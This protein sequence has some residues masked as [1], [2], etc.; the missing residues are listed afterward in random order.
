M[1]WK[2]WE[3]VSAKWRIYHEGAHPK[4]QN[5]SLEFAE[6]VLGWVSS[7]PTGIS[8]VWKVD[9]MTKLAVLKWSYYQDM[10]GFTHDYGPLCKLGHI[11]GAWVLELSDKPGFRNSENC[12]VVTSEA[13]YGDRWLQIWFAMCKSSVDLVYWFTVV[14]GAIVVGVV[15]REV[16]SLDI[17]TDF[18]WSCGWLLALN[19]ARN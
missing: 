17:P 15:V 4:F 11:L 6:V 19:L 2:D 12:L 10:R 5:Q 13:W 9:H 16:M 14:P 1:D 3:L 7:C 8:W 18:S